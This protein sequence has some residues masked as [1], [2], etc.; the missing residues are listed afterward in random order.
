MSFPSHHRIALGG[1]TLLAA[2]GLGLAASYP[3][4][5]APGEANAAPGR[6]RPNIV[7]IQTDDQTYKQL[8]RRTMPK[9]RRLLAE[10]GTRFT[11]YIASTAQCCPSRA[12]LITGQ[13]AHNHGVT[14][15]NVGYPGLV[16]KGNVLPVWLRR[17]GYRTIHV[18]K[19]LNGYERSVEPNSVVAPGWDQWHTV[20]GNTSYYGY[21]LFVNGSVRHYGRHRGDHITHVLNRRAVRMVRRFAPKG[22]PFYLQLDERAPHVGQQHDPHGRCGRA[23]IPLPADEHLFRNESL[24]KPPSFN[25]AN[26]RDKP[27][28][29]SSV[30]KVGRAER[31]KIRKHWRCALASLRGVDRGVGKVYDAV[32]DAG[33][34]RKTVFIFTSDNGQFHGQHRLQS[35]KVLPYEEALH[36]PLLIK[37]PKRYRGGAS[38]VKKVGRPVG[39]I[40]LAPTI[41]DLAHARPCSDP[42]DCRT[43]DGRSLMPLLRR[44]GQWPHRRALLTEYRVADAGRYATCEFVGIRTRDDVYVQHSRVVDPGTGQCVPSDERE[45]YDL[46]RDPFELRNLC[47]GGSSGNCPVGGKQL[48]LETRL[49]QLQNCAGIAGRDPRVDGQPFCE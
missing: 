25:E 28:F 32:K 36:L 5:A 38:R 43:M 24:P 14:S 23:P 27:S 44:S 45:R 18:G 12:S 20:L 21:D 2:A 10:R 49:S 39:N 31:R 30:P 3:L 22:H 41:L 1:A 7:L 16:D 4:P 11:D 37:A 9:T 42:G 35:G 48:K 47:F 8:T 34:L 15:N 46:K 19:F 13:Y 40:D 29:L 6:G 26:M 33:D 17:A